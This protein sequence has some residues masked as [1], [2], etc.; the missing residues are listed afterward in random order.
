M[1]VLDGAAESTITM[2]ILATSKY[3]RDKSS[4][5]LPVVIEQIPEMSKRCGKKTMGCGSTKKAKTELNEVP[6]DEETTVM[7]F[8]MDP[9][10]LGC[11]ICF[12]PLDAEV[13]MARSSTCKNGHGA[14]GNC[15][16]RMNRKCGSCSESIGDLRNR[17]LET[18]LAAMI[19]TC[20]FK[21]YGCGENV[22]WTE[23]RSHEETCMHAPLD[24]PFAGCGY[25]GLQLYD[26]VQDEHA[27]DVAY[28]CDSSV[29][30]TLHKA[31]PFVVIVQPGLQFVYVLINGGD[32]LAGRSLSLLC[33]GSCLEEAAELEY[34]ME[35]VSGGGE[36]GALSLSA[37]GAVPCAR[38]LDGF[39]AKQFLFVPDAYWG[40]SDSVSVSVEVGV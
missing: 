29:V 40:A 32:V 33:L 23:K 28:V 2:D 4:C 1:V 34:K 8:S 38:R 24:C 3:L 19:T 37:A 26:H 6:E 36:P 14:C 39:R 12:M 17:Q 13:Y 10:V 16:V 21:E 7:H 9:D 35:V 15:C 31:T 30:T 20:K 27:P 22:K 25:R 5:Y 18:V 11:C